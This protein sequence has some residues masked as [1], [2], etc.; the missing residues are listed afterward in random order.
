MPLIPDK[1]PNV[2][3]AYAVNVMG[4][5]YPTYTFMQFGRGLH[6]SRNSRA[7]DLLRGRLDGDVSDRRAGSPRRQGAAGNWPVAAARSFQLYAGF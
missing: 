1:V 7:D 2:E 3:R 4:Q 5:R 6:R